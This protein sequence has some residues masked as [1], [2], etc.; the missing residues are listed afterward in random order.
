MPIRSS[1]SRPFRVYCRPVT[2]VGD[3]LIDCPIN[4]SQIMDGD[5]VLVEFTERKGGVDKGEGEG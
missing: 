1:S 4:P 2:V 5:Y 3:T